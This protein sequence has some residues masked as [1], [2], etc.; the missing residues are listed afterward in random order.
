MKT[1]TN[2]LKDYGKYTFL[3]KE[4]NEVD[5]VVLSL[6][7]YVNFT[8]I[9]PEFGNGSITLKEATKKFH[10]K[11]SK[12]VINSQIISIRAVC[13][14]LKDIASTKRF[15]NL[16]LLNYEYYVSYD[17]QFGALCIKLPNRNM[18]ISFEGT[19]GYVSGWEE[20]FM[21]SYKFPTKAQELAIEY[22][23]KVVRIFGPR[24]YVGGHSK[25][26]NLA[27]VASM[28]CKRYVYHRIRAVFN[29]DG[30]GL[31]TNEYESERYLKL[32]K[33]Y[34]HIV[35]E[36]SFFGRLLENDDDFIIVKSSK[37]GMFQHNAIS[38]AVDG[39]SFKRGNFS[40][41]SERAI[42]SFNA[43]LNKINDAKR[44][45]FSKVLFGVLR[46]AG[47]TDLVEVKKSVFS[48][49]SKILKQ[50]K[51]ISKTDKELLSTTLKDLYSE[52][53]G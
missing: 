33:K 46:D 23:N 12:K 26:G 41:F 3:D 21:L 36:D 11:Y 34:L 7:S 35:P 17:V 27:L 42:T 19:D 39:N 10:K 28:Y 22:L 8:D 48:N 9:V 50:S 2:Y 30:P 5:N 49:I 15:G 53:K 20:D 43:W 52:W 51:K 14:I 16:E 32:T 38:W 31:R 44:E 6:L 1:I 13:K 29:N 37:K 40:K 45:E 24:V 25:G 47:V 4:F 18:Y